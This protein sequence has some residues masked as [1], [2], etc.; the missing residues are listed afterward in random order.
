MADEKPDFVNDLLTGSEAVIRP[1]KD[2]VMP[3]MCVGR[4]A[5]SSAD[6]EARARA[7]EADPYRGMVPFQEQDGSYS[8]TETQVEEMKRLG[9]DEDIV[10]LALLEL[11]QERSKK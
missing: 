2:G 10:T 5:S 9:V 6:I 3:M 11:Q 4:R 7:I 8:Y 1:N